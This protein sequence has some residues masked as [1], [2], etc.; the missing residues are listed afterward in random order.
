MIHLP[1]VFLRRK[2]EST[3]RKLGGPAGEILPSQNIIII[4]ITAKFPKVVVRSAFY[5][6]PGYRRYSGGSALR[7]RPFCGGFIFFSC[8]NL[9][10]NFSIPSELYYILSTFATRIR[11]TYA[12]LAH[13]TVLYRYHLGEYTE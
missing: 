12:A 10:P 1:T 9:Q 2:T 8:Y 4:I 7:T 3:R 5:I 13:N 11:P 6:P